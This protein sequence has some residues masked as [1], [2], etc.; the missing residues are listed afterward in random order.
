MLEHFPA[1]PPPRHWLLKELSE[2]QV[3]QSF[4]TMTN[5]NPIASPIVAPCAGT[6]G[7]KQLSGTHRS[8]CCGELRE[9]T[10][11]FVCGREDHLRGA[12]PGLESQFAGDIGVLDTLQNKADNKTFYGMAK[13]DPTCLQLRLCSQASLPKCLQTLPCSVCWNQGQLSPGFL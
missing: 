8:S 11:R 4:A 12:R 1:P 9:A 6:V 2:N 7:D 13:I 3:A 10:D 5:G